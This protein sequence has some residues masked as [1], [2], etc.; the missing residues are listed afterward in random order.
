MSVALALP[1]HP[2]PIPG[3][4]Q[5][6]ALPFLAAVDGYLRRDNSPNDLRVTLHRVMSRHGAGYLQ[7][8]AP[9]VGTVAYRPATAGRVYP[10]TQG[11]IGRAYK[12]HQVLRTGKRDNELSLLADLKDD[13]AATGDTRDP[14]AVATSYLAIPLLFGD[15]EVVAILYA[16][17]RQFNLFADDQLVRNVMALCDGFC[18]TFDEIIGS[19]LTG[20]RNYRLEPGQPVT[21]VE[22]VYP[23]LQENVDLRP[24]PRFQKLRSFNFEAT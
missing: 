13:M 24:V 17:A 14:A 15:T 3:A 16:E 19:P 2:E 5:L 1:G 9:Y 6:A 12:D 20:I 23:K 4:T 7:Q 10:V 8:V 21:D 22:T 11:I 18:R